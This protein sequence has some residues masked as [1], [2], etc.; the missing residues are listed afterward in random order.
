MRA[1]AILGPK[2]TQH[3]LVPFRVA[4]KEIIFAENLT[5]AAA[6]AVLVLGGDGTV[7]RH[8]ADLVRAQIPLLVIPAGSANDFARAL[9]LRTHA[10]ALHA[11]RRFLAAGDNIRQIDVGIF[12]FASQAAGATNTAYFSCAIGAGVDAEVARRANSFPG[13]LRGH[14]GYFLAAIL[15]LLRFQAHRIIVTATQA[16]GT[17]R[18]ISEAGILA[19]AANAPWYGHGMRIAP[20]AELDDGLLEFCFV[21]RVGKLRLLRLFPKIYHGGHVGLPEV[22]YF[23]VERLRIESEVPLA[24]HADGEPLGQTPVE[25]SVARGALRVIVGS[26]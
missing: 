19:A 11:W 26:I 3:D 22:E 24:V 17:R 12:N 25:V 8:L 1:L 4:G 14:G 7:Q 10:E 21:R 6:D 16:D 15:A 23:R 13:W 2:A 18:M 20:Q 5:Q 9:G